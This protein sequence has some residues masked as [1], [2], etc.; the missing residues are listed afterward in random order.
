VRG[1]GTVADLIVKATR[2]R[3]DRVVKKYIQSCR[4]EPI[5]EDASSGVRWQS[6]SVGPVTVLLAG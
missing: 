3:R 6:S 5:L 4:Y 2:R 1:D